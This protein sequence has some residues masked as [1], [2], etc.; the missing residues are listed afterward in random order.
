MSDEV[1]EV[2]KRPLSGEACETNITKK[3]RTETNGKLND[4]RCVYLDYNAT[5]PLDVEVLHTISNT[6]QHAWGNPSSKS[7]PG[8]EAAK[9]VAVA[10]QQVSEMI[11]AIPNDI[12]FTSGGTESNNLVLHTAL[13]HFQKT[14]PESSDMKPHFITSNIEHDAVKLVLEHYKEEYEAEVTYVPVSHNTGAVEVQGVLDAIKS[15]TCLISI[16]LANNETGVIQPVQEICER[17]RSLPQYSS[18]LLHTDAAQAIGKIEVSVRSLPVDYLTIVGH[19]FY[20]PRIGALYFRSSKT[21]EQASAPLYPM[22]FGG[23]QER[24]YRPGTENTGMIAGLGKAC[25]LVT[26]NLENYAK[27]MRELRS[28]FESKLRSV[29]GERLHINGKFTE[30]ERLPNTSNVSIEGMHLKGSDVLRNCQCTQ[31][32]VGAACHSATKFCVSSILTATGIPE[33]IAANAM[34]FSMG[35][36]TTM[37]DIDTVIFDIVKAIKAIDAHS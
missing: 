33:H 13:K 16:M 19:K 23:G 20:G 31:A 26:K 6:L 35:R 14:H 24:N 7:K 17:V 21:P 30:S 36:E 3:P 4:N 34:R 27:H 29:Y 9:A 15:N 22:F 12:V 32:S 28:Y 2:E 10:R 5:T 11:Q 8:I 18:I 1:K 37:D 25:Y